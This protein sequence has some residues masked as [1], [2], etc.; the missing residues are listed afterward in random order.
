MQRSSQRQKGTHTT[1]STYRLGPNQQPHTLNS[2]K[3]IYTLYIPNP[4]ENNTRLYLQI[5]NT[6]LDLH[7]HP[8]IVG[9][10]FD[11]KFTYD[12]KSVSQLHRFQW[13]I[14]SI[15]IFSWAGKQ[16]ALPE[17]SSLHIFRFD[18]AYSL[19]C[20]NAAISLCV[21]TSQ[22]GRTQVWVF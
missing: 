2:D 13:L 9:P 12:R 22:C 8:K 7:T 16:K 17:Q 6:T 10:A 3:T 20:L 21:D 5:N 11:R 19:L 15:Q 1:M 4:T 14:H 18:A